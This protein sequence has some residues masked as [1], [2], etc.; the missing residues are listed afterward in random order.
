MAAAAPCLADSAPAPPRCSGISAGHYGVKLSAE[1][2]RRFT[3]WLDC[4]SE[5]FGA[6]ENTRDQAAGKIVYPS[7]N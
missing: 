2:M 1:D 3:L 7:L 5:F 6:Y 4:N